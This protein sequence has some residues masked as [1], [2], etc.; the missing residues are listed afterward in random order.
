VIKIHAD[1][2]DRA[3]RMQRKRE[4]KDKKRAAYLALPCCQVTAVGMIYT[5]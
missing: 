4:D 3:P 5:G 2:D 1:L